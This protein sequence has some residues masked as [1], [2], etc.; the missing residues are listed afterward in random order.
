M[1]THLILTCDLTN[2]RPSVDGTHRGNLQITAV[3]TSGQIHCL[4][5]IQCISSLNCL[6]Q[7]WGSLH[8]LLDRCR[9]ELRSEYE[10]TGRLQ[11]FDGISVDEGATVPYSQ[12]AASL[13]MSEGALKVAVHRLRRRLR[14][15]LRRHINETVCHADDVADEVRYLLTIVEK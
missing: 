9:E 1:R 5:S 7:F 11:L 2:R 4:N 14:E 15:L 12:T 10:R 8:T 13:G 6:S 3:D